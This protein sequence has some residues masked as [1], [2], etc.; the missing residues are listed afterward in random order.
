I[1]LHWEPIKVRRIRKVVIGVNWLDEK[2]INVDEAYALLS[3]GLSPD[4]VLKG[5]LANA[6]TQ[7]DYGREYLIPEVKKFNKEILAGT[8][9]LYK[10]NIEDKNADELSKDPLIKLL[11]KTNDEKGK[12]EYDIFPHHRSYAWNN[13]NFGPLQIPRAGMKLSID[14]QSVHL[15]WRIIDVYEDNDL[16]IRG[17]KV[18]INGVAVKEYT[19]KQDYYWMMGDNRHNSADSRSW[20]FVPFDH[21]VG[22]PVFVWFSLKYDDKQPISGKWS[23][24]NIFSGEKTGK[25]RWSRF[26]CFVGEKGLSHSYFLY[27]L[28]FFGGWYGVSKYLKFR[29]KKKEA[30]DNPTSSKE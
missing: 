2:N 22:T 6:L 8:L 16:F 17:D 24:K 30:A 5:E 26:F 9:A 13:D 21:V 19:F 1:C 23:F 27:F 29:R 7:Q 11:V 15:Y 18:F 28:V 10:I 20:G 12:F 4:S 14:T 25:L 3:N